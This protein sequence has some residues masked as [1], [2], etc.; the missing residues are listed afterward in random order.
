MSLYLVSCYDSHLNYLRYPI[1][2]KDPLDRLIENKNNGDIASLTF[3]ID[4]A[5]VISF[6]QHVHE[7]L[8]YRHEAFLP[9]AL[10][11]TET[12][13]SA[14]LFSLEDI[15]ENLSL[16]YLVKHF[17]LPEGVASQLYDFIKG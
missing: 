11:A 9:T 3:G 2:K 15:T 4:C 17:W 16:C 7:V 6:S 12:Y 5:G 8:C 1:W 14:D 13:V 10:T